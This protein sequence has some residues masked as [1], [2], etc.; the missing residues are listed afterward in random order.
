M[1]PE[2]RLRRM[3][4]GAH[5]DDRVT[6]AQWEGFASSARR[7]LRVPRIVSGV[8]AAVVLTGAVVGAAAI[9]GDFGSD[10]GKIEP[11]RSPSDGCTLDLGD[12]GS[13]QENC[14]Y[15]PDRRPAVPSTPSAPPSGL[16]EPPP[17]DDLIEHEVW[18]VD[19]ET[20]RLSWGTRVVPGGDALTVV[21]EELLRGPIGPDVESGFVTEIPKGTELVDTEIVGD[22]AHIVLS[23]EFAGA[24]RAPRSTTYL[25]GAQ[26]VFTATQIEGVE[27]VRLF[28]EQASG[29][30]SAYLADTEPKG[31]DDYPDVAPAI[32]LE[33]P[34][35]NAELTSPTELEGSVISEEVK[36]PVRIKLDFSPPK[37]LTVGDFGAGLCIQGPPPRGICRVEFSEEIEFEVDRRTNARLV[38]YEDASGTALHAISLPVILLPD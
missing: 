26:V 9:F 10:D 29:G 24:D 7:S 33:A 11:V 37:T 27:S 1:T 25:R 34:K 4:A 38:V 30:A 17:P 32:T 36:D 20:K 3:M 18:L 15:D 12:P 28:V 31:R 5:G 2:D 23:E 6:E 16:E 13:D 35:A 14:F 8:V 19:P 22:V 21:L